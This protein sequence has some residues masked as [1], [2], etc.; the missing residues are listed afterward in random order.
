ML[1][2]LLA[3]TTPTWPVH[4]ALDVPPPPGLVSLDLGP[5]DTRVPYALGATVHLHHGHASVRAEVLDVRTTTDGITLTVYADEAARD[6]VGEQV[7][8]G[9]RVRP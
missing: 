2:L 8:L 6:W 1:W 7:T 9:D 5:V 3:C 4:E